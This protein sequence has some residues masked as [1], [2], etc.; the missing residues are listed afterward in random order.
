[1]KQI[2][3]SLSGDLFAISLFFIIFWHHF[4]ILLDFRRGAELCKALKVKLK[5]K[6]YVFWKDMKWHFF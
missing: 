6:S 3:P 5:Q 1:M 2:F 4:V